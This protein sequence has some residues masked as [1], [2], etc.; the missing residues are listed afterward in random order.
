MTSQ[1]GHHG[2]SVQERELAVVLNFIA[3]NGEWS[4]AESIVVAML[5][6]FRLE[7]KQ[8]RAIIDVGAEIDP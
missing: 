7:V 6:M 2:K 3:L 1:R 8:I 4:Q 5:H